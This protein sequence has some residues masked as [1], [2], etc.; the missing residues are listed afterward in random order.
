MDRVRETGDATISFASDVQAM[1]WLE[2]APVLEKTLH[3][4]FVEAQVN[5]VTPR[6]EFF[7]VGLAD[8]RETA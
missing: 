1:T 5:K 4:K 6:K 7:R 2:N 8:L 3:R